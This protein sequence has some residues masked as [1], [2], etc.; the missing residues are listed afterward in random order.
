MNLFSKK[1]LAALGVIFTVSTLG[2][3]ADAACPEYDSK[4]TS[5]PYWKEGVAVPCMYA[6]TLQSAVNDGDDHNTFY[7][8]FKSQ[9]V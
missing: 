7:W 3:N 5:L 1:S 9:N 6:G 4:V 2:A 8:L